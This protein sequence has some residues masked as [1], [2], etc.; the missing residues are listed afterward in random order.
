MPLT[1][2]TYFNQLSR[3]W[4][5]SSP[6]DWAI[7]HHLQAFGIAASDRVLDIGCGPGR[8]APMLANLVG[9]QGFL[10]EADFAEE[11]LKV[12]K[13]NHMPGEYL[14]TDACLLA[15]KTNSFDKIVCFSTF[16]HFHSPVD[17]LKEMYRI[18]KIG[19]RLLILHTCC[20]RQLNA[21]H[22]QKNEVVAG[23]YLPR[24]KELEKMLLTM[25]FS[26]IKVEENPQL[27]LVQAAK[28]K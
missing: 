20:S 16:P 3:Q 14:C 6:Q 17:A 22:A 5:M 13:S 21:F 1:H 10:V 2:R 7:F 26:C 11:M 9:K 8:L 4:P 18:L 15:L 24:A 12:A 27:Y 28:P 19:G 23:D 25:G